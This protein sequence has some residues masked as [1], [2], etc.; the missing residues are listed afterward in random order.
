LLVESMEAKKP[1]GTQRIFIPP[2]LVIRE[3]SRRKG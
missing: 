3:S 1:A 2:R